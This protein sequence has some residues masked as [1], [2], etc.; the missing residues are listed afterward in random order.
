MKLDK[1]VALELIY[2]DCDGY[3]HVS[4]EQVSSGRWSEYRLLVI[5]DADG[6]LWG[7]EYEVGLTESQDQYPWDY[8]EEAEFKPVTRKAVTTYVYEFVKE[9]A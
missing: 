7:S 6:N 9:N 2:G 4:D 3:K 1:E 5:E 8:E